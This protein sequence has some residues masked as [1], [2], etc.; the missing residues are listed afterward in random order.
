MAFIFPQETPRTVD[1][2]KY[3]VTIDEV[4]KLSGF[5]VF[6]ELA[7]ELEGRFESLKN[8]IWAKEHFY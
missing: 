7:D 4:E 3:V 8:T 1:I 2:S 5:D 6:W